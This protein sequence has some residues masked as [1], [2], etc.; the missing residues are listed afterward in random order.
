MK[1][2]DQTHGLPSKSRACYLTP[3]MVWSWFAFTKIERVI[4]AGDSIAVTLRA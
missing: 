2:E 3:P 4:S 1:K